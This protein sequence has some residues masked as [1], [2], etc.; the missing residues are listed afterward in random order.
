MSTDD[1]REQD[2]VYS[3]DPALTLGQRLIYD[4]IVRAYRLMDAAPVPPFITPDEMRRQMA[5]AFEVPEELLRSAGHQRFAD[6]FPPGDI[7]FE[8]RLDSASSRNLARM[9]GVSEAVYDQMVSD[10]AEQAEQPPTDLVDRIQQVIDEAS[11]FDGKCMRCGDP[12]DP[13]GP[14]LLYCREQCATS[15]AE[16]RTDEGFREHW[17]PDDARIVAERDSPLHERRRRGQHG[18]RVFDSNRFRDVLGD[19]LSRAGET[20]LVLTPNGGVLLWDIERPP[21]ARELM[22]GCTVLSLAEVPLGMI[23][24]HIGTWLHRRVPRRSGNDRWHSDLATVCGCAVCVTDLAAL[25]WAHAAR[26]APRWAVGPAP[27]GGT[28]Q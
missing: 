24:Q 11:P 3:I 2:A 22:R 4:D 19:W 9:M 28:Q 7:T 5:A 27:R 6:A 10:V 15:Y 17:A 16:C 23:T 25:D 1:D 21:A 8:F 12:L 26:I 14:S 18:Q 20:Y 13:D